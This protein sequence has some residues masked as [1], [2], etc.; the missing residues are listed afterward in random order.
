MTLALPPTGCDTVRRFFAL[1]LQIKHIAP[2]SQKID[3]MRALQY[4]N[5]EEHG[6]DKWR[7]TAQRTKSA[8]PI[9]QRNLANYAHRAEW[10]TAHPQ[11]TFDEAAEAWGC[12][13]NAAKTWIYLERKRMAVLN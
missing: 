9:P 12:N 8:T 1:L 4:W 10:L 7:L 3:V 6:L 5:E 2:A 13:R 11:C